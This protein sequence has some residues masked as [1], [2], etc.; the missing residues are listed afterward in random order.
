MN[1]PR[2][3]QDIIVAVATPPGRGGVGVIRISGA[4]LGPL[5]DGL[6]GKSL[7]PRKA[8][9]T[10][11]HDGNHQV[12]DRGLAIYFPAPHSFTGEHVLELQGQPH[13]VAN[14]QLHD[15]A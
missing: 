14:P 4:A 5:V 9:F 10:D 13:R 2:H 8:V 1:S 3:D 15:Q 6:I 11:F 7:K 12:I